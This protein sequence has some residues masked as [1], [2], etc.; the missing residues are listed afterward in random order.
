MPRQAHNS[1][2][3]VVNFALMGYITCIL[4]YG[5]RKA[6]NKLPLGDVTKMSGYINRYRLRVGDYRI[7]F[8]K[9]GNAIMVRIID[10]RGQAYK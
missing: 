3:I 2:I 4:K 8:T 6:V 5:I 10:N 1:H 7:I 9:E